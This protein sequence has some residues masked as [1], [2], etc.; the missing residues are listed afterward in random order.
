MTWRLVCTLVLSLVGT[1]CSANALP[2][3]LSPRA[4]DTLRSVAPT[5][6]RSTY[7]GVAVWLMGLA[8]TVRPASVAQTATLNTSANRVLPFDDAASYINMLHRRN[9]FALTADLSGFLSSDAAR[10][11]TGEE[12]VVEQRLHVLSVTP[13]YAW[14]EDEN[15]SLAVLGGVRIWRM[16][17]SVSVPSLDVSDEA[18]TSYY[19]VIVATRIERHLHE[20]VTASAY[21]DAG[22]FY[23]ASDLTWQFVGQ[24][25]LRTSEQWSLT[26][27]YRR[28]SV[29]YRGDGKRLS[30]VMRGGWFGAAIRL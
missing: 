15:G 27:G 6:T 1:L 11:A 16:S 14:F 4:T 20:R 3:Q 5:V 22:G 24:V 18:R 19:D 26:A 10:L 21:V 23:V 12:A 9:R 30:Q 13:G 25:A 29:D 17:N 7:L 8:G 2:A 28:L